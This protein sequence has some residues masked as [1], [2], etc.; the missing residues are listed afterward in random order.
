MKLTTEDQRM[1]RL[2]ILLSISRKALENDWAQLEKASLRLQAPY[3][4]LT[5]STLDQISK[6]MA[7]VKQYMFRHHLKVETYKNDGLFTEYRY[8]CRGYEGSMKILNSHLKSQVFDYITSSFLT[9][10]HPS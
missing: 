1:I 8:T 2:F 10:K 5:R 7:I 4:E 3:L 6:E 9:I